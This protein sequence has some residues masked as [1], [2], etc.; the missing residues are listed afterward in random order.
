MGYV[1]E[2]FI[3]SKSAVIFIIVRPMFV[4]KSSNFNRNPQDQEP[5]MEQKISPCRFHNE[6]KLVALICT[7]DHQ[8]AA[9]FEGNFCGS[10]SLYR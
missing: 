6:F 3:K 7:N 9:W 10:T 2:S 1:T 4:E 8:K 5:G